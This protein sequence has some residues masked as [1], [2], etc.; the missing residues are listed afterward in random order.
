MQLYSLHDRRFISHARRTRHFA[1]S[2]SF[3]L[4][5]ISRVARI[6]RFARNVALTSIGPYS[7]CYQASNYVPK[8]APF[9]VKSWL[10]TSA[11]RDEFFI[12]YVGSVWLFLQLIYNL[13]LLSDKWCSRQFMALGVLCDANH[14]GIVFCSELSPWCSQWVRTLSCLVKSFY[15]L[16]RLFF[17]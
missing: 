13:F 3:S 9:R 2:F 10:L 4:S 15:I 11:Y 5:L 1:R 17:V 16:V 6:S 14:L 12:C 7:A 8:L